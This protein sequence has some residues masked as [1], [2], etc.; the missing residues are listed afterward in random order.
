MTQPLIPPS[1]SAQDYAAQ[2]AAN[3][4]ETMFERT[5][6]FGLFAEWLE[7]AKA[8][9][10]NDAN[11]MTLATLD[12]E[13]VPDA[14]IVLLKDVDARG[15]TFFSNQESAKG[16]QLWAHPAA[17]LVFHWK[18]LRR[19][20]RVRGVVEPVSAAE[21]D[22]YFASRARESRIGAWA[23]DQ[24]RPLDSR[25]V[26]EARVAEQTES[27]DGQDVPRPDRWSG[28][29]IVPQ[30]VEFWRDRAFRLHDRLRFER[31]GDAWLRTRLW[32]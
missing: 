16:E 21:A 22:A 3:A 7:A 24:S 13:G 20:V 27:F 30:Q 12:A 23:S 32:P 5:E 1:P 17:A 4:D 6:P 28:W 25:A 11:A 19:Q 26:L 31:D 8:A 29:R 14:R 2:L 10:P 15:F 9:E 18:S